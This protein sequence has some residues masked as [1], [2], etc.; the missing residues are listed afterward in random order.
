GGEGGW[1]GRGRG[2]E[3]DGGEGA[4]NYEPVVNAR[5]VAA[6]A[7]ETSPDAPGKIEA[8]VDWGRYRLEVAAP[9]GSISSLI[10]NSGYWADEA[11]DSPEVLDVALDKPAYRTGETARLRI[12]SRLAR[13]AMIAVL[14]SGLASGPEVDVPAGGGG[15][16]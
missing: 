1:G 11:A 9:D 15:M 16:P 6:G 5:R 7:S 14:N 4:W 2:W 3:G 12:V 10:F 8:R 13:R